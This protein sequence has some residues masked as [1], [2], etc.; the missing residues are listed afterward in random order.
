MPDVAHSQ[1]EFNTG[2]VVVVEHGKTPSKELLEKTNDIRLRWMDFWET[3]TGH[4]SVMAT[5]T[6]VTRIRQ[7]SKY[8]PAEASTPNDFSMLAKYRP[9]DRKRTMFEFTLYSFL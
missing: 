3:T 4:R 1:K 5:K 8:T 7:N 2:M 6:A 9:V